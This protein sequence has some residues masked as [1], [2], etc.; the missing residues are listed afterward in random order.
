MLLPLLD[1]AFSE[2]SLP[3]DLTES[4]DFERLLDFLTGE[5]DPE[6]TV[7]S[8]VASIS[9]INAIFISFCNDIKEIFI[10]KDSFII[11]MISSM[12]YHSPASLSISY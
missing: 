1:L 8:L 9:R 12:S 5:P 6:R 4:T 11:F 2:C 3:R 7:S 10:Y